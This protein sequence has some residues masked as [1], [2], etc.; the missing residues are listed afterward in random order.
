MA[1]RRRALLLVLCTAAFMGSLDLF[2]V[3]VGLRAIGHDVGVTSLA[4][5]S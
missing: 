5:L 2:I 4:N 1:D 3:N